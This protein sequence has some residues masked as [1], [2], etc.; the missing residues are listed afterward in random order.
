MIFI[1]VRGRI[2]SLQNLT[3]MLRPLCFSVI[4]AIFIAISHAVLGQEYE[5]IVVG[6]GP[7]GGPLA[8]NLA[9]AGYSVLLLEAGTDQGSNPNVTILSNNKL[10]TNDPKT[11]WDFFVKH[12]SDPARELSYEHLTWRN[13]DGTFYVGL[14]PPA[15]ATQLGIWYPRAATLGGCATHNAAAAFLPADANWDQIADVTGDDSWKAEAMRQYLV[16]LE[17]NEYLPNGTQGHGFSGYLDINQDDASWATTDIDA[18]KIG[19]SIAV[20]FQNDPSQ[21][22]SLLRRDINAD[23]P[24]RDQATGIYGL[25]NHGD[26][27]GNRYSPIQYIHSTLADAAQYNLTVQ[28]NSLVSTVLF[29]NSS[30]TSLQPTAI[31]VEYL[32]GE[33]LYSADPRHIAS[34]DQ[35]NSTARAYATKEVILAGGTFNSPQLLKLSGIGPAA[36]LAQFDIPLIKD[37]KGVG[38]NLGDNYEG[39]I[40]ALAARP[41]QGQGGRTP[42]FLKTPTAE[43][44]DVGRDSFMWCFQGVFEGFWPGPG[45]DYG[46]AVYDCSLIH[47]TPRTQPGSVKLRS[48]DPRDT[49]EINFE[50][51]AGEGGEDDLQAMSEA[52]SW[53]RENILRPASESVG[54]QSWKEVHP[55][56]NGT[57]TASSTACP[58]EQQR[59]YLK[60]QAWSHHASGSCAIGA[61]GDVNAVLDSD[62][63]VRGVAGLRV[64]DASVFPRQPGAFPVLPTFMASEKASAAILRDAA[65]KQQQ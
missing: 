62:F 8:A 52:I 44:G 46:P 6:S 59:E 41:L 28:F 43:S 31:G 9:R 38:E 58:E 1:G 5:Y 3:A 51:F 14:D 60:L 23:D 17:K 12:S 64:V 18:R 19:E 39:G 7:G 16:K 34:I 61:E 27:L 56:L 63:R 53:A 10:A 40:V 57:I 20:A 13:T 11:R 54:F 33:S 32:Q 24:D 65:T 22:Q 21:L 45:T 55:C 29:D 49:P 48:A 25:S 15:G 26:S 2:A 42:F 47:M 37:L 35:G 30:G 36:E 4:C 50:Y